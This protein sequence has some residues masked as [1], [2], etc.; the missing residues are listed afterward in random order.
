MSSASQ[1]K[2]SVLEPKLIT[3][4]DSTSSEIKGASYQKHTSISHSVIRLF[5]SHTYEESATVSQ[6]LQLSGERETST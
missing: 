5:S 3:T 4:T 6:K 2:P 1:M